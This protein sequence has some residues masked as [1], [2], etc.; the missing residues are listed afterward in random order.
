MRIPRPRPGLALAIESSADDSSAAIVDTARRI[1]SLHTISQHAQNAQHGGIH[2]LKAQALHARNVPLAVERVLRDA[3]QQG[4]TWRDVDV[5]GYTRGPGMRGCLHVGE[6]VA[7]GLAAGWG[8]PLVGVHHMQAH[9]LTPLLTEHTPPEFPFLV[10]LL[11]G[12]H[13]Q[14]VLAESVFKFK[15]LMDTLDSKIGDVFEKSARLLNLPPSPSLSPGATLEH[16]ASLPPLPPFAPSPSSSSTPPLLKPLPIPLTQGSAKHVVGWSFAGLLAALSRRVEEHH[17]NPQGEAAGWGEPH[18]RAYSSLLQ[19]ATTLHLT[20]KLSQTL[21]SLSPILKER[22][23]GMAVSGG[24]ASN[25]F[26][27]AKLEW[28]LRGSLGEGKAVW[29]PPVSLCTDNAAMIAWTALLRYDARLTSSSSSSPSLSPS[30]S[31]LIQSSSSSP[32]PPT[33]H[34]RESDPDQW[35]GDGYA[36]DLRP[37]WS[38]EDLYDDVPGGF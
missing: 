4:I 8:K 20:T 23:S 32:T 30:S 9:A 21:S 1:L 27:R 7:K 2:P 16:Y 14:L 26:L 37:K 24:V 11:S 19:H 18:Q 34:L 6:M 28:C 10:L 13:T 15:I 38:L 25:K 35:A 3:R 31:P 12:G 22:L 17:S 33:A 36:L 29:Y 5:V